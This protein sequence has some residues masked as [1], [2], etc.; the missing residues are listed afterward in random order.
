MI[1]LKKIFFFTTIFFLSINYCSSDINLKIVM[2]I[3]NEIITTYDLEQEKNYLLA[4]NPNLR[5]IDEIQLT[6]IAKKSLTKETIRKIEILKYKELKLEIS[7]IENVLIN[8]IQNLNF[9]NKDEFENYL[10]NFSISLID[11]KKK[12]EIENEWKNMIYSKY[13]NSVN[14]NK[15]EIISKI[16]DFNK[17]N[18]TFEY[19]LSEIV[20]TIKNNETYENGFQKIKDSININ[21]FENTANLFSISDSSKVGGKIGWVAKKNLSSE[22]NNK[23]ENL[24]ENEY[25]APIKIGNN[26]LI[27]KINNTRKQLKE[28]DKKAEFDKMIFIETTKQL[29]K[30]SNIFYNKIKLNAKISEF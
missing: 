14:I 6:K 23:I 12:I 25:S 7:Q 8:L 13:K 26:F 9:S 19:N 11:L 5:K 22:I 4:L 3:N 10:K 1:L 2:K 18:F 29:E 21:G 15:E 24:S 28:I 20:F 27:L 17:D 30:F 16:N